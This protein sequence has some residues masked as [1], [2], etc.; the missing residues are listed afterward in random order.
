MQLWDYL[1]VPYRLEAELVERGADIWVNR[2]AYPEL[3]GCVIEAPTLEGAMAGIEALRIETILRMLARGEYPP[4]PRPPLA[5]SDPAWVAAQ[6][7]LPPDVMAL[8]E[9]NPVA[10]APSTT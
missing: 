1:R 8:L 9:R 7:Q 10:P 4:V 5:A 3:A 6:A 2:L